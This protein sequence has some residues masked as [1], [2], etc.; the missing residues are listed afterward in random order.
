[1]PHKQPVQQFLLLWSLISPGCVGLIAAVV[2]F[3]QISW[4]PA[5]PDMRVSIGVYLTYWLLLGILQG[6]LLFWQFHDR[7]WA[8]RWAITTSVTGFLVM[9]L[10]DLTIALLGIDTRGQGIL[11]LIL[12]LPCLVVLGSMILGETQFLLIQYRFKDKPIS[13]QLSVGWSSMSFLSWMVGFLGI[14]FGSLPI[15]LL[16][17]AIGSLL[18]GQFIQKY[19]Q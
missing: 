6:G 3:Y 7:Q 18:K 12:S 5:Y 8:T 10:H 14:V 11:I 2:Q 1:M 17:V 13:S 16:L 9:L 15:L 19:F 4:Y